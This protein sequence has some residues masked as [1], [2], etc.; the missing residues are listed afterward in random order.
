MRVISSSPRVIGHWA[1]GHHIRDCSINL[2]ICQ[3]ILGWDGHMCPLSYWHVKLTRESHMSI[4]QWAYAPSPICHPIFYSFILAKLNFS[5]YFSS[6][7]CSEDNILGLNY[8][9]LTYSCGWSTGK[10]NTIQHLVQLCLLN[11]D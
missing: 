6:M 3:K 7:V 5:F 9:I 1:L 8:K 10:N 4:R 11:H 2:S